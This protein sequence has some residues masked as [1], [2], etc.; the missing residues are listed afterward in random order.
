[1]RKW[2]VTSGEKRGRGIS[3][4]KRR[5][6]AQRSRYA[7]N[8]GADGT[9]FELG[10]APGFPLATGHS[11]AVAQ[12]AHVPQVRASVSVKQ[13]TKLGFLVREA[14]SEGLYRFPARVHNYEM[15]FSEA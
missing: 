10:G 11:L 8:D 1:M 4:R 6:M 5:A 2:R 13:Q 3:L 12:L 14:E 7:R 15:L 9:P